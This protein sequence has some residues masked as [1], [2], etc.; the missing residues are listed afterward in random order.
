MKCRWVTDP[1]PRNDIFDDSK[2]TLQGPGKRLKSD[3][4]VDIPRENAIFGVIFESLFLGPEKSFLSHRK[5][6]VWVWALWPNGVSQS[7][8]KERKGATEKDFGGRYRVRK[9]GS[10][11]KGVFSKKSIFQRF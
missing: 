6:H 7:L 9:K 11:G 4:E 2:L 10:F 3:S 1:G 8:K 5:C